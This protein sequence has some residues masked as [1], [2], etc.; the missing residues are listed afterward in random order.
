V[1]VCH[2]SRARRQ[3]HDGASTANG[4]NG[5]S[6]DGKG[7][8]YTK[9]AGRQ[10]GHHAAGPVAPSSEAE[11]R[12]KHL[13]SLINGRSNANGTH[14]SVGIQESL[15]DTNGGGGRRSHVSSSSGQDLT[16]A[17]L[18]AGGNGISAR[19]AL[20]N[21]CVHHTRI[22]SPDGCVWES[23]A[24]IECADGG[25]LY[26]LTGVCYHLGGSLES[27]HYVAAVKGPSD[28]WWEC[29]DELCSPV[30][31]DSVASGRTPTVRW[32]EGDGDGPGNPPAEACGSRTAYVLVY[33]RRLPQ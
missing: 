14:P 22:A 24:A 17:Q 27:G 20:G 9:L 19:R 15:Q 1:P 2:H 29:N 16:S 11:E 5:S 13:L 25:G 31:S 7:C 12:G 4:A 6:E 33:H 10:N 18:P 32:Y 30:E 21:S 26:D 23:P 3:R 8:T 28:Q